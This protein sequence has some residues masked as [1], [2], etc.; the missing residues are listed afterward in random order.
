MAKNGVDLEHLPTFVCAKCGK[1]YRIPATSAAETKNASEYVVLG[2][3]K[4]CAACA[5]MRFRRRR[6]PWG[7]DPESIGR[8]QA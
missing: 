7:V 8:A 4:V 5:A 3:R 6:D 1:T 2:G